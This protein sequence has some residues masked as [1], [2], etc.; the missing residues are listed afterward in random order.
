MPQNIGRRWR[1][2]IREYGHIVSLGCFETQ[3][4]ALETERQERFRYWAELE[5]EGGTAHQLGWAKG[6]CNNR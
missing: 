3:A 1:A 2:R 5:R 4:E 6:R